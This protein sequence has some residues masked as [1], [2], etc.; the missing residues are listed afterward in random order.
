MMK[1]VVLALAWAMF[2]AASVLILLGMTE[3]TRP[4]KD[5][6]IGSTVA[7]NHA[8]RAFVVI[9]LLPIPNCLTSVVGLMGRRALKVDLVRKVWKGLVC[10]AFLFALMFGAMFLIMASLFHFVATAAEM[11]N[12]TQA[13]N[14]LSPAHNPID[15]GQ[16]Q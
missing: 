1:G 8:G 2:I 12:S 5:P 6:P 3:A 15:S 14:R 11:T 9:F 7:G 10:I 4:L 13:K 16:M